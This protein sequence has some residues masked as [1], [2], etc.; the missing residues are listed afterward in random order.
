MMQ[1]A[2]LR[3]PTAFVAT[4]MLLVLIM[5]RQ[6]IVVEPVDLTALLV[7][8]AMA[9]GITEMVLSKRSA[10]MLLL[11]VGTAFVKVTSRAY[12][13]V[14]NSS[15][16]LVLWGSRFMFVVISSLVYFLVVP[17]DWLYG[18]VL[19]YI[20]LEGA[21]MISPQGRLQRIGYLIMAINIAFVS[22]IAS[23]FSSHYVL[24]Y[25][26][27]TM[28]FLRP[29]IN[30]WRLMLLTICLLYQISSIHSVSSNERRD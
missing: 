19:V 12:G 24:G 30:R 23:R 16:Q 2:Q 21:I 11:V 20:I 27:P 25:L 14:A 9:N 18:F 3:E 1:T 17:K 29:G 8:V 15:S 6:A 28:V 22:A 13:R 4:M 7:T 26:F 5:R 10:S